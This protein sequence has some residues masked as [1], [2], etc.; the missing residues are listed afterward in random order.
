MLRRAGAHPG[1]VDCVGLGAVATDPTAPS[2]P[3]P[4]RSR[5]LRR[6][7]AA[8]LAVAV[9]TG[10]ARFD[11]P[12][13][14][15]FT[16]VPEAEP[17][18]P[19]PGP[20]GPGG[21]DAPAPPGPGEDDDEQDPVPRQGDC[22]DPDPAVVAAC[23]D[24]TG[25]LVML[26]DGVSALVGE[27]TTGQIMRVSIDAA[28]HPQ[29]HVPVDAAGDGGLTGLA[30]S[31]TYEEDG[32]VYAY[33]TTAEDNRVVRLAAGD[34]PKPVLTGL[35]RGEH[36]NAGALLFDDQGALTVLTGDGGDPAAAADPD[37]RAGK[38]LRLPGGPD[39]EPQIL[40]GGMGAGGGLCLAE[41]RSLWITDR[42]AAADRLQ[43]LPD[44]ADQATVVWSWPQR[45]GIGGCAVG[46][47]TVVVGGGAEN[48]AILLPIGES[49]AVLGDPLPL[50]QD[51][52]GRIGAVAFGAEHALWAGTVNRTGGDP[53]ETDDRVVILQLEAVTGPESLI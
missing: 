29:L 14:E 31:P 43:R 17:F 6:A 41:D 28:P 7:A 53:A 20:G 22:P 5:S 2:V 11:T 34:V 37:S 52:Y 51:E 27:R 13:N 19:G 44:G 33:I 39:D 9:V 46:D 38:V 35:P 30:L 49:G 21:P 12:Y 15:A 32:L 1:R 10:C 50:S 3:A 18:E 25:P 47:D 26:P 42:T 23:L 24:S 4:A 45:P 8:L 36:G 16:P 40:T 48:A